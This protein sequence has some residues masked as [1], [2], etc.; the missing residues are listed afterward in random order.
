MDHTETIKQLGGLN[1]LQAMIN[2]R[3]FSQSGETLRFRFSGS[4]QMNVATIAL[5]DNDT[6]TLALWKV[7]GAHCA[8]RADACGIYADD[9]RETF[10]NLTGLRLILAAA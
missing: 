10:E 7:K 6:Y 8:F 3:D 9:L 2:A 5:E 1:R 4:D